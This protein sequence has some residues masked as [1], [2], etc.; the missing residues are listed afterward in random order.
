MHDLTPSEH[1]VGAKRIEPRESALIAKRVDGVCDAS[2]TQA[3]QPRRFD[4]RT[5]SFDFAFRGEL[6]MYPQLFLKIR[7]RSSPPD[8][9]GQSPEKLAQRRHDALTPVRARAA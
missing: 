7:V 4:G 8:R 5:P 3:R 1:D 6:E 2:G 9:A